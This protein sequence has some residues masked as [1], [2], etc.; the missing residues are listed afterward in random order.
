[1]KKAQAST[2]FLVLVAFFVVFLTPI[3]SIMLDMSGD[4]AN[5]VALTQG[6]QLGRQL[7]DTADE[8]YIQGTGASKVE[9]VFFPAKLQKIDV[10]G[11]DGHEITITMDSGSGPTELVFMTIGTVRGPV[12]AVITSTCPSMTNQQYLGAGLKPIRTYSDPLNPGTVVIEY[13]SC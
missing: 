11:P 5:D 12:S 13:A 4:K 8:I 6:Q 7:A 1:M 9:N 2:E 3:V 10:G